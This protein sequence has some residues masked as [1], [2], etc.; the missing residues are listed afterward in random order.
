MKLFDMFDEYSRKKQVREAEKYKA[1][2]RAKFLATIGLDPNVAHSREELDDAI[3]K[4]ASNSEGYDAIGGI[5]LTD[6]QLQDANF[7]AKLYATNNPSVIRYIKPVEALYSNHEHIIDYMKKYFQTDLD[8]VGPK[9]AN[10][11]NT[12]SLF[13]P[14]LNNPEFVERLIAEFPDKEVIRLVQDLIVRWNTSDE[15]E[16]FNSVMSELSTE[17]LISQAST[18]G[19]EATRFVPQSRNDYNAIIEASINNDG[20]NSLVLLSPEQLLRHKDLM[21]RAFEIANASLI[22]SSDNQTPSKK[23]IMKPET[24]FVS[25]NSPMQ[26]HSYMCHGDYH[27]YTSFSKP[28]L[29][30]QYRIANDTEF[31]NNVNYPA[32]LKANIIQQIKDCYGKYMLDASI[33]SNPT[34]LPEEP[35]N[36]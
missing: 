31:W 32:E 5:K 6:E 27:S 1:Q 17:S 26:D 12:M 29:E 16:A 13:K 8:I 24:F 20:F 4:Y 10:F 30:F 21:L 22:D 7:M 34:I 25:H 28:H 36:Q 3:I 35:T 11:R 18:F 2:Q 9:L 15:R 14:I 19:K 33:I 23:R